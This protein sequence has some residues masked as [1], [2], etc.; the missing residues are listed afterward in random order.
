VRTW[1]SRRCCGPTGDLLVDGVGVGRE[2]RVDLVHG[3]SW[4]V[5][6]PR[7]ESCVLHPE[8]AEVLHVSGARWSDSW[9]HILDAWRERWSTAEL[10]IRLPTTILQGTECLSCKAQT[11]QARAHP[12][13][14]DVTCEEC[15]E[16]VALDLVNQFVGTEA[17]GALSPEE[18]G[19]PPWS[20][21]EVSGHDR[22]AV[23]ELS[24]AP[25]ALTGWA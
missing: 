2:I 14:L 7:N 10:A 19:M 17:W 5:A 11:S 25:A 6:L 8:R 15:G 23:F 22:S 3:R 18:T 1:C 13:D 21:L 9:L 16:V 24:G 20:W 4:N 12:G